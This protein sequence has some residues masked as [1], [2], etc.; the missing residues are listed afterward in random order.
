MNNIFLEQPF[1]IVGVAT[2]T[3]NKA[4]ID[5]ATIQILWGQFFSEQVLSKVNN[6]IDNTIIALYYGFKSDKNGAYTVLIGVK[7]SSLDDVPAGLV[8]QSVPAEQRTIFMSEQGPIGNIVFD[9]W[10]KIWD[11]EDQ[12]K[13]DRSYSYDYELYDERSNDPVN[14]QVGVH[15]GIK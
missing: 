5:D 7:V 13:L 8:S 6:R 1:F 15:I 3:T 12:N 14:A 4:A 11:L 9:T 10:Q 2:R